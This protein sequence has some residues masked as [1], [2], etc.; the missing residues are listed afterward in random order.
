MGMPMRVAL[1][2]ALVVVLL[3]GF[4]RTPPLRDRWTDEER[5]VLA[6]LH[7]GA[8]PPAPMDASNRV[9]D[10]PAAAALGRRFFHE[11]RFSGDGQVSCAS[12][13]A[14]DKQ[15]QD[16]LPVSRGAGTGTRRAMPV[17]AAAHGPWKFWDGRKDSLWSQALGP[18]EDAAEHASNRTRIAQIVRRH[19][20]SEYEGVFGPLPNGNGWPEDAGPLGSP[21]QQRA[22]SSMP[23]A[24]Q[25]EVNRVFANVGKAIAAYER[26]VTYGASRFDRYVQ[27]TLDRDAAGQQVLTPAEV[28]GLRVFI[29]AGQC[30]TCH[31]GPL[32][33]DHHFHN[34]GVP[35]RSASRADLGRAAAI[36]TVSRDEFNCLG[37]YSDADPKKGCQELRFL[38]DEGDA[39][40]VGAFKTPSLRNVALR[41][42][43]MHA[44][45]IS[46][47]RA[48][49]AHYAASPA[50]KVGHSELARADHAH[51]ERLPI[52]LSDSQIDEL[53]SFLESLSG[54]VLERPH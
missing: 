19:Y 29:G 52:R 33:T 13:H 25:A 35:Q 43:Y 50:A 6:T 16:G 42:P 4:S 32:L 3:S 53:V 44:G 18:L 2:G 46:T 47:L 5:A 28:R 54:P 30:A 39:A 49:V 23:A 51:A 41:A 37:P 45:Q 9:E 22:W 1:M 12:C 48:V 27:A 15:F 24:S 31:N 8:L 40:L 26:G 20:S 10:V 11:T 7:I 36:A 21:A 34:T 17:V 14:A 38:V